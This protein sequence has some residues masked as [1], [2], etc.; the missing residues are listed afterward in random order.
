[1]KTILALVGGGNRD[2][3]ICRTALAAAR[4]VAGH[5]E[6]LH[7]HVSPGE[8]ARYGRTDFARGAALR[9]ALNDLSKSA[10]DFSAVAA[11]NVQEFCAREQIDIMDVATKTQAVTASFTEEKDNALERLIFRGRHS[12]LIVMGRAK[13][14]QGLAPDTLERLVL[15]CGRP[16][17]VAASSAPR[18]LTGT[19]MVCWK[20]SSNAARAVLAATPLLTKTKRVVFATI[21]EGEADARNGVDDLARQFAWHGVE[22]E[23]KVIAA[24]RRRIPDLLSAA[25]ADCEADL[26]VTGAYGSSGARK[27]L[28]GSCT[29][30]FMQHADKPIFLMH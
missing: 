27:L 9:N 19:I 28:F 25:A 3:V 18:Q 29:E 20:D 5:V 15:G 1:M 24:N 6:F 8:A 4:P 22:T 16:L 2:E 23:V 14:T 21:I 10:Q 11:R 13:Q 7:M 30:A 17:L 12:D 26:V